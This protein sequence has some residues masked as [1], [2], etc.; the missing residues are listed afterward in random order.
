M[1]VHLHPLSTSRKNLDHDQ[2]GT[3][4]TTVCF[5]DLGSMLSTLALV[6]E[7]SMFACGH[8]QGRPT[9]YM[10]CGQSCA[11]TGLVIAPTGFL[12]ITTPTPA[13]DTILAAIDLLTGAHPV[14]T[15]YEPQCSGC[16][17]LQD[18]NGRCLPNVTMGQ[19][20]ASTQ[21]HIHHRHHAQQALHKRKRT[22][23]PCARM[24]NLNP[25]A[26]CSHGWQ[27]G[28]CLRCKQRVKCLLEV[29]ALAAS[30]AI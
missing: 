5:L 16:T 6:L 11:G 14:R 8:W 18:Q 30:G 7:G 21:L 13:A 29:L 23:A 22:H 1:P 17:H 19:E 20:Q 26:A 4:T 3:Q 15:P 27:L 25:H 9:P 2:P 12:V 24:S 28:A 10:Y